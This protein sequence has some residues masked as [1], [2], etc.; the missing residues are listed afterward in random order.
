MKRLSQWDIAGKADAVEALL[1]DIHPSDRIE[2]IARAM[3]SMNKYHDGGTTEM[4]TCGCHDWDLTMDYREV[5][6][7]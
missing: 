5:G 3:Y 1:C 7:R 4:H 2:I 6:K